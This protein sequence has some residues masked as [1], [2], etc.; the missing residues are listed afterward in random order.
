MKWRVQVNLH[1]P[2]QTL[3]CPFCGRW[4]L[5]IREDGSYKQAR[6]SALATTCVRGEFWSEVFCLKRSCKG[7]LEQES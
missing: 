4:L 1:E 3:T 7:R 2:A 6:K 5:R